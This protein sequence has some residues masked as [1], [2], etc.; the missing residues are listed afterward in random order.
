MSSSRT[1]KSEFNFIYIHIGIESNLDISIKRRN[2]ICSR[3]R[4]CIFIM[5]HLYPDL[6]LLDFWKY[7]HQYNQLS[8]DIGIL[9]L[10]I[11][12]KEAQ[13]KLHSS[14]YSRSI[15]CLRVRVCTFKFE[16]PICLYLFFHD[17]YSVSFQNIH[18]FRH[19]HPKDW[20]QRLSL[21]QKLPKVI[22]IYNSSLLTSSRTSLYPTSNHIYMHKVIWISSFWNI[23]QFKSPQKLIVFNKFPDHL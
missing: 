12:E 13:M 1:I 2:T 16:H 10:Y 20:K 17:I 4:I 7:T 19:L 8:I 14:S 22:L 15:I 5:E 23:L 6:L 11:L 3:V 9:S 18:I 21:L